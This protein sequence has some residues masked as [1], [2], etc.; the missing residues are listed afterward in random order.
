MITIMDEASYYE[1]TGRLLDPKI[2]PV[3]YLHFDGY[4]LCWPMD[5]VGPFQG[6]RDDPEVTC[7][8]C[9]NYMNVES[10]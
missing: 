6:S 7:K 10:D 5:K 1:D 9:I 8:E 4:P 3:H 2:D